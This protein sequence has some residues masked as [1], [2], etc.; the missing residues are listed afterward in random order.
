MKNILTLSI[1]L[2]KV[3]ICLSQSKLEYPSTKKIPVN[4]YYFRDTVIDNYQWLENIGDSSITNFIGVQNKFTENYFSNINYVKNIQTN[5]KE[6]SSYSIRYFNS[7]R[8]KANEFWLN[9]FS[10]TP[11]TKNY[12]FTSPILYFKYKYTGWEE[13]VNPLSYKTY[14]DEK[15]F[16]TNYYKCNDDEN[17]AFTL[18]R[19]GLDWN[20]L[21]FININTKKT[22]DKLEYLSR[23][24]VVFYK[25]GFFYYRYNKVANKIKD[26]KGNE[27]IYFHEFGKSQ[28]EDKL[29]TSGTNLNF[30]FYK[31]TNM[32]VSGIKIKNNKVYKYLSTANIKT[33][34]NDSVVFKPFLIFPT[35]NRYRIDII[36]LSIDSAII[37]TNIHH[38]NGMIEK[39][40][41]NSLSL[42]D[43]IIKPA[44]EILVD[45]FYFCGKI[46][47]LYYMDQTYYLVGYNLKGKV[48]NSYAFP[49]W[50]YIKGFSDFKK[51][52]C[53]FEMGSI[54]TP[55]RAMRFNFKEYFAE[56]DGKTYVPYKNLEYVI[57]SK[58]Y[59]S[60]DGTM[61][62]IAIIYKRTLDLSKANPVLYSAYGGFGLISDIE[63]NLKNL[64]WLESGGIYAFSYIRG[65]GEKGK[66]WHFSGAAK[67][68]NVCLED[69][70][71]GAKYLIN[72][73]Y[74]D[75]SKLAII[76]SS[77]GGILVSNAINKYP[78]LFKAAICNVG[79][80]DM[81]RYQYYS[82]GDGFADEFGLSSDSLDY[83]VLKTYSPYHNIKKQNYPATLILTGDHDDRVV[84]FHSYKYTAKLREYNQSNSPIL[85]NVIKSK[86]HNG[87]NLQDNSYEDALQLS[88]LFNVLKM[89]P[90]YLD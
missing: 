61:I 23:S 43:T 2:F 26:K 37:L 13:L 83:K 51:Y 30:S 35:K 15:I 72:N 46:N 49:K 31:D 71:S 64:I 65:G 25:Q 8:L 60:F 19:N 62:S 44:Q 28:T 80:L 42:F 81:L 48:I 90:K 20:E 14:H 75:C 39:Y 67:N 17:V 73:H 27:Y 78:E 58:E 85:L 87:S 88:F 52:T 59:K 21:Y 45:A 9:V 32:I 84:P 50:Y 40:D 7:T 53:D 57:E 89:K 76:G 10:E 77:H 22:H 82:Y 86:G 29:I 55:S 69:F 34:N 18:S 12:E 63:Y 6:N 68:K 38:P 36:N 16:I 74:T 11:L 33:L 24:E 66:T 47:C 79:L 1:F 5:I 41:I 56:S 54:V 3:F 4:N 70:I